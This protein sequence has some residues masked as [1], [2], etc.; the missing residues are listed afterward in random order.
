MVSARDPAPDRAR[1]RLFRKRVHQP[2]DREAAPDERGHEDA[3]QLPALAPVV[4]P[5]DREE[6]R[7]EQRIERHDHEVIRWDQRQHRHRLRPVAMSHASRTRRR[8]MTPAV[9]RYAHPYSYVTDRIVPPGFSVK[10]R[11][12]ML[13]SPAPHT[14]KVARM[15]SG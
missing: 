8:F 6:R 7:D 14:A 13:R 3:E 1:S 4:A 12:A 15:V 10:S 2:G 5:E 9:R 11:A